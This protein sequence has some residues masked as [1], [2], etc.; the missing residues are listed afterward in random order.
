MA[1][2]TDDSTSAI[3][4]PFGLFF[5]LCLSWMTLGSTSQLGAWAAMDRLRNLTRL[6][7]AYVLET[8][9]SKIYPSPNEDFGRRNKR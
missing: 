1:G 9:V 6:E 7:S 2:F 4:R 8:S 3:G 5:D